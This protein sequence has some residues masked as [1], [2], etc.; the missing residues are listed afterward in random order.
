MF[1]FQKVKKWSSDILLTKNHESQM[2]FDEKGPWM[3]GPKTVPQYEVV[4]T[5]KSFEKFHFL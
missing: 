2:R 3:G 1:L 5:Q 4:W